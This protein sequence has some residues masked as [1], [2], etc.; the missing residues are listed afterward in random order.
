[1]PHGRD[2]LSPRSLAA[3]IFV[4]LVVTIVGGVV[5]YVLTK[6]QPSSSQLRTRSRVDAAAALR[7][8][9]AALKHN[10]NAKIDVMPERAEHDQVNIRIIIAAKLR[11]E[12]VDQAVVAHIGGYFVAED[13]TRFSPKITTIDNKVLEPN[14]LAEV[15]KGEIYRYCLGPVN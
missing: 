5:V 6:E 15:K 13:G 3:N 10:Q 4:G 14:S 12:T 8:S 7:D 2:P 9:S 1:M 11:D